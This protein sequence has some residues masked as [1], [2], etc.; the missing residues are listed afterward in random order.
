MAN[1]N[2]GGVVAILKTCDLMALWGDEVLIK[3]SSRDGCKYPLYLSTRTGPVHINTRA[4]QDVLLESGQFYGA[5]GPPPVEPAPAP[6]VEVVPDKAPA[7]PDVSPGPTPE[8]SGDKKTFLGW[9]DSE[10][11]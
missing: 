10:V 11:F 3:R 5:A 4:G 9:L 8:T 7:S 6:A 2:P 1:T